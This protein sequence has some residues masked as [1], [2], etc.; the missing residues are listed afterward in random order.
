MLI[1]AA[2]KLIALRRAG[3]SRA[4]FFAAIALFAVQSQAAKRDDRIEEASFVSIGGIEQ[5]VKEREVRLPFR[6]TLHVQRS[7][8][9][10]IVA[11]LARFAARSERSGRHV[12]PPVRPVI[13]RVKQ[14]PL[15]MG[16][17]AQVRFVKEIGRAHV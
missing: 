10:V 12:V 1:Y 8:S 2:Q 5:W 14:Q 7:F 3:L 6:Q 9:G 16:L 17:D 13:D 11:P 4:V 15:M